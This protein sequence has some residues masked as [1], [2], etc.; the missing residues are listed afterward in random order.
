MLFCWIL[1]QFMQTRDCL[2]GSFNFPT[3]VFPPHFQC[4]FF[5]CLAS[6]SSYIIAFLM[7]FLYFFEFWIWIYLNI[8]MYKIWSENF[9]GQKS[10]VSSK[11]VFLCRFFPPKFPQPVQEMVRWNSSDSLWYEKKNH[12][13]FF[14][15]IFAQLLSNAILSEP[16]LSRS[17][18]HHLGQHQGP[19][20]E[21]LAS[22]AQATRTDCV[23]KKHLHCRCVPLRLHPLGWPRL[24]FT[25]HRGGAGCLGGVGFW[26]L[27]PADQ[28]NF[29]WKW[30]FGAVGVC[31]STTPTKPY[32]PPGGTKMP[33]PIAPPG[34]LTIP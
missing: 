28:A 15:N 16:I 26:T 14:F 7:H 6:Y 9:C 8:F 12:R 3:I 22:T 1:S 21:T 10:H 32:P 11:K 20:S 23:L 2:F 33:Y 29:P 17:P 19:A 4:V 31:Y 13:P 25:N 18:I 5:L 27:L 34:C 30:P 24:L